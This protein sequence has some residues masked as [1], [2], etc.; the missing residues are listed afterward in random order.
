MTDLDRYNRQYG[1]GNKIRRQAN[2]LLHAQPQPTTKKELL[3]YG[4]EH[5]I[6]P[7][8]M[9][10][11]IH[12]EI[13]QREFDR[14]KRIVKSRRNDAQASSTPKNEHSCNGI[15]EKRL[16]ERIS[17]V[18]EAEYRKC[19]YR[20][21]QAGEHH[22]RC[23]VSDNIS[24]EGH[25]SQGDVYSSRCSYFRTN[26]HHYISVQRDWLRTVNKRGMAVCSGMLTLAATEVEPGLFKAT[27][28]VQSTGFS[29]KSIDGYIDSFG[30][31]WIHATTIS[32][33]KCI[34]TRR[35]RSLSGER[36]YLTLKERLLREGAGKW[37]D[38][39]VIREDSVLAGNCPSGTDNW[40]ATHFP[41]RDRATVGEVLAVEG[42]DRSV[43]AACLRAI[44]RYCRTKRSIKRIDGGLHKQLD[45][46]DKAA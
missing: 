20:Q 15:L 19:H 8:R 33:V 13:L 42:G 27:W 40:I 28:V 12:T 41:G 30:D 4:R 23:R 2:A 26:S 29:V 43:V 32:G 10:I 46:H 24:A 5:R 31:E 35:R 16:C 9:S 37:A 25:S 11:A 17:D 18:V 36:V 14:Q 22:V 39:I 1:W 38:V 21:A 34:A 44:Q 45:Q 6:A 7:K 3:S